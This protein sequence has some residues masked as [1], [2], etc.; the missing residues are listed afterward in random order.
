VRFEELL[1]RTRGENFIPPERLLCLD[2]GETTGWALFEKGKLTKWGQSPT[3]NKELQKPNWNEIVQL[4]VETQPTQIVCENYR[5][6]EHKLAQHAGAEIFTVR[7]IGVI[8]FFSC[9]GYYS[10][11]EEVYSE[12]DHDYIQPYIRHDACPIHYQMAST[13][14]GFCTDEKLKGWGFWQEGMRHS[15][16][17]IRH[18]AYYLLFYG[19]SGHKTA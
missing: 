1:L 17:A 13:A 19:R 5:V 7:L 4:F 8:D 18:G 11:G 2:P 9:M 3:F 10:E 12:M 15:R 6:Y 14:K 16:D